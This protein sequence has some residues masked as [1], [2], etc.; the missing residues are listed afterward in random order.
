MCH[1]LIYLGNDL[2]VPFQDDQMEVIG[3]DREAPSGT[4]P[5][6]RHD[7]QRQHLWPGHRQAAHEAG[8]DSW[9]I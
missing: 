3:I 9:M 4:H 8:R 5:M 1:L 2:G 7:Q 6:H